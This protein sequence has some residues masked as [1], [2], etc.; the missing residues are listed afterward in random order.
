MDGISKENRTIIKNYTEKL[1]YLT[2]P[3]ATSLVST[4]G[5]VGNFNLA[6]FEN[7]MTISN[8][9]PCILLGISPARDTLKNILK[10]HEFV[11]GFPPPKIV[12][13]V[14]A[15]GINLPPEESEFDLTGLT[16]VP[17]EI[18]KPPR[19][20]ECQVNFECVLK[21]AKDAGDHWVVVGHVVLI[22]ILSD[23]L[24]ENKVERRCGLDAVYYVSSGVFM[25]KGN[26]LI[27]KCDDYVKKYQ[28]HIQNG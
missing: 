19:I 15:A 9:P 8:S 21:W 11:V 2:P 26:R 3:Q 16:P 7:T 25:T 24:H 18:I 28:E 5:P 17:S 6:A 4:I 10:N 20:A 12:D 13:Q 22:D 23:L 27:A 1:V 14:L